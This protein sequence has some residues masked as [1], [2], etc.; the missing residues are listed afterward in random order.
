MADDIS[1]AIN[2]IIGAGG[3]LY[4]GIQGSEA[5]EK[6]A[7]QEA[8]A[9]QEARRRADALYANN[10]ANYGNYINV[11]GQAANQLGALAGPTGALGRQFTATDFHQDP[12]YKWNVEQALNQIGQSNA[13]RGGALSGA[14]QKAMANYA[15]NQ[16]SNEYQNAYNRFTQNQQQ[17]YQQLSGLANMG[18]GGTQALGN[19]G[20][21]QS[22]TLAQLLASLGQAQA[23]GTMG[24][25]NAMNQGIGGF[26]AGLSGAGSSGLWSSLGNLFSGSGGSSSDLGDWGNYSDVSLG[27]N[28]W[29]AGGSAPWFSTAA[30]D[31]GEW[32]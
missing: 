20:A 17:N 26:L 19:L 21:S 32:F 9:L 4:Q 18:L 30:A 28:D 8:S 22:Q 24:S 2:N 16:G 6:A 5:A 7:G 29:G 25:A 31:T 27:G 12:A 14:A 11:G 10:A 13:T 23:G 15:M 3:S 1:N